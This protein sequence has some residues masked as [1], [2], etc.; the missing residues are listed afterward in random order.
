M[1]GIIGSTSWDRSS[2]WIWLLVDD[3]DD[4]STA[5]V[6]DLATARVR[7]RNVLGGL[8]HEYVRTA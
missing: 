2:A 4:S 5:S 1:Q 6:A 7:R 3:H 8:I